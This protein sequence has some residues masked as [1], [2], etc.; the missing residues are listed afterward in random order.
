[1]LKR[2]YRN[3]DLWGG[4]VS[5]ADSDSPVL[6]GLE[7]NHDVKGNTELVSTGIA[8]TNG[9]RGV[10]NLVGHLVLPHTHGC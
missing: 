5:L 8:A 9:V 3:P 2:A 7:V 1:M 6:D 10:I 4:G